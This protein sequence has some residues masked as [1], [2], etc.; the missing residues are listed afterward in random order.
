MVEEIGDPIAVSLN[1][2][3]EGTAAA[4]HYKEEKESI[5]NRNLMIE[6]P[7]DSCITFLTT[8]MNENNF[9]CAHQLLSKMFQE[10]FYWSLL[11]LFSSFILSISGNQLIKFSTK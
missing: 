4:G 11:I 3:T 9:L 1:L 8:V 7:L 10:I 6:I 2:N 5:F